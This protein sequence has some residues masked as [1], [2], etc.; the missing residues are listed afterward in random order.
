MTIFAEPDSL[1]LRENNRCK[2]AKKCQRFL[3]VNR[4]NRWECFY[5][6]ELGQFCEYFLEAKN[7]TGQDVP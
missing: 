7:A 5:F 1:C 6:Q 4:E 2:R 3:E